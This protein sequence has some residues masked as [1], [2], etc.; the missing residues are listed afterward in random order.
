MQGMIMWSVLFTTMLTRGLMMRAV[1][2]V[3]RRPR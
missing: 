2:K 3:F 1:I